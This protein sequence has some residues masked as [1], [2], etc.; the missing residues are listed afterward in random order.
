MT[1]HD[2]APEVPAPLLKLGDRTFRCRPAVPTWV[3]MRLSSAYVSKNDLRTFGAMYDFL[4]HAIVA[5]DWS[6]F[7]EY[8]TEAELDFDALDS[9]I[10]DVLAEMGGRGKAKAE[11]Y[12]PSSGGSPTPET[13]P[14]SRVV[15]LSKGTVSIEEQGLSDAAVSST[16]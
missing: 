12:G 1:E 16:G 5:D 6:A 15:S 10:G 11:S 14:T 7:E 9:A 4:G 2:A 8:A 13:S 3:I